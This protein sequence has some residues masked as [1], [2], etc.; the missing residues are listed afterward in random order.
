MKKLETYAEILA[1]YEWQGRIAA[2]DE[3]RWMRESVDLRDA[4]VRAAE[5]RKENGALFR[6]QRHLEDD[7]AAEG[8]DLLLAEIEEV[9]IA[10]DFHELFLFVEK[11]VGGVDGLKEMFVYDVAYRIGAFRDI[12]PAHVYLHRGTRDGA[13]VMGFD[14]TRQWIDVNEFPAEFHQTEAHFLENILC[15]HRD[16]LAVV[17]KRLAKAKP[18]P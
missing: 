3:I 13:V 12:W 8:R 15:T 9:A 10:G 5:S 17:R 4:I 6:H 7:R 11:L 14:G 2:L 16:D 18:R 1:H